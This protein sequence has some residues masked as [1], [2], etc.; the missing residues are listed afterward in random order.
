MHSTT[1]RK[2]K[3]EVRGRVERP[4]SM[5][6]YCRV[7]GCGRP[8]T[9]GT[10]KGLNEKFCRRHEEHYERHGSPYK[11]SYTAAQLARHRKAA[12]EWLIAHEDDPTVRLAINAVADLY[13][14]AGRRVEAFRLAGLS[15]EEK[16]R[17]MWAMLRDKGIHAREAVAAW[18]AVQAAIECDPQAEWKQEFKRVQAA[19]L[20]HRMVGGAHKRWEIERNGRVIVTELHKHPQSR[21]RVLRRLGEQL[22]RAAQ[23]AELGF[24]AS[25]QR[26]SRTTR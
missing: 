16:A 18:L 19:K 10:G 7:I 23:I 21:G 8:A 4:N 13:M 26:A 24:L 20:I 1:A 17:S 9:A 25:V 3:E 14:R 5:Y 22:E 12:R 2:R 6:R 15:P 11:R